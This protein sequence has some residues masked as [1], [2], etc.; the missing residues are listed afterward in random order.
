MPPINIHIERA[1][2]VTLTKHTIAIGGHAQLLYFFLESVDLLLRL[3]QGTHQPL[4]LFFP[5]GQLLERLVVLAFQRFIM[6]NRFLQV[7][8][9]TLRVMLDSPDSLLQVFDFY[10]ILGKFALE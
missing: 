10:L 7:P 4:V 3:L 6:T 9:K 1:I 5:L 2:S 8:Y